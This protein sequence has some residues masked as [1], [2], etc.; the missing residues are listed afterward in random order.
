MG[1]HF[2]LLNLR[3]KHLEEEGQQTEHRWKR[4]QEC[5]AVDER[6]EETGEGGGR[7]RVGAGKWHAFC[8]LKCGSKL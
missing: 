3:W 5:S 7:A 1:N 2:S 8:G 6:G 4:C